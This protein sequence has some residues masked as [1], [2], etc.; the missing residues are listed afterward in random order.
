MLARLHRPTRPLLLVLAFLA[1]ALPVRA[2]SYVPMTDEALVDS[3]PL[4]AVVEV[5]STETGRDGR[6][7]TDSSVRVVRALKGLLP[8]GRFIVRVP[9]GVGADGRRLHIEGAPSLKPGERALLFLSPRRDGTFGVYQLFLGS[10]HE[11]SAGNRRLALRRLDGARAVTRP[12]RVSPAE[13]VRD[14][15]LFVSW[16]AARA[17]GVRSPRLYEIAAVG[18]GIEQTVDAFKFFQVNGRA[19]RWFVFDAGS[20]VEWRAHA[21]GQ[22]GLTGGGFSEFQTALAAW[23][24]DPGTNI[25]YTY[26][27]TTTSTGGFTQSDGIHTLLF[28]DPNDDIS[29]SFQCGGGGVLAIGGFWDDE[30]LLGTFSGLTYLKI[31]EG[32]IVTNQNIGCYIQDSSPP[33]ETA[34]ELFAHELGHTL[35]LDHSNDPN[36]LMYPFIHRDGR[37]AR[38]ENDEKA[39]VGILYRA[40]HDF[41]TLTPCRLF[42]SRSGA[43]LAAGSTRTIATQGLCGIPASVRVLAV[44]VTAVTP[45]ASGDLTLFA[46]GETLPPTSTTSFSAGLTRANNAVVNLSAYSR[47]FDIQPGLP[48]G[49]SVHVTVDVLGYFE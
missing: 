27:G 28:D 29:G 48:A 17:G 5:L 34:Q 39:A 38:L 41:Y 35:G 3:A 47:S 11:V 23:T 2:T 15:D 49:G 24:N 25:S 22:P 6:P 16:I 4:I 45:S 37:G 33:S 20:S 31:P 14:F 21:S 19:F 10:F 42:D 9:G 32:D 1:C 36:A 8:Q 30:S 44:N 46:Q 13:P 43:P 7:V 18:S 26:A 40:E 12:G